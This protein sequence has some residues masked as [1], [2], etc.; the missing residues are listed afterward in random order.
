MFHVAMLSWL[1]LLC[2]QRHQWKLS[3]SL[4]LAFSRENREIDIR[5]ETTGEDNVVLSLDP[6]VN[7]AR[8]I[9]RAAC[10]TVGCIDVNE[11]HREGCISICKSFHTVTTNF[12]L[13]CF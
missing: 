6:F 10:E 4:A 3:S 13:N 7:S 5:F 2:F 1:L 12:Y 8:D 9:S 11:E